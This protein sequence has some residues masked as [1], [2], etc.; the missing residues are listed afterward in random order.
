MRT[1]G[2]HCRVNASAMSG[3][4]S[5]RHAV[6]DPDTLLGT[7]MAFA[8]YWPDFYPAADFR[9]VGLRADSVIS[10]HSIHN[11]IP[12]VWRLDWWLLMYLICAVRR[13][14]MDGVNGQ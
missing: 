11:H 14:S 12:K 9:A 8:C 10:P 3:K 6:S 4:Q 7:L 1:Y 5:S 2:N 13:P